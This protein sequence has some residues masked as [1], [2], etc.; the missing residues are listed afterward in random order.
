MNAAE[1]PGGGTAS[2]QSI[3]IAFFFMTI[4][5]TMDKELKKK[6]DAAVATISNLNTEEGKA[7]C[8]RLM[9]EAF[10][11]AS[12]P[13]DKKEAGAYLRQ[14]LAARKRADV[15]PLPILGDVANALSW[16]YIAKTYF[17]KDPTWLYHK[18]NQSMVN[19]KPAA[20][21]QNELIVL[22]DSLENL[23]LQLSETSK[24]IHRSL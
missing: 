3:D 22:A 10:A 4:T 14:A 12:T 2:I 24:C 8:D 16:S 20:F 17:G 11:L 19:G 1:P 18:L 6:I 21:T 13:E 7:E 23:S 5:M 15:S 9:K